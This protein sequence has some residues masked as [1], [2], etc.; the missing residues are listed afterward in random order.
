MYSEGINDLLRLAVLWVSVPS[1]VSGRLNIRLP[2]LT[3]ISLLL[4]GVLATLP[5]AGKSV[6][7]AQSAQCERLYYSIHRE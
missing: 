4:A 3:R 1:V 7:S 6:E 5:D 2:L